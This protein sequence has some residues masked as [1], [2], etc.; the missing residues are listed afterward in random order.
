MR[1]DEVVL[2]VTHPADPLHLDVLGRGG[3]VVFSKNHKVGPRPAE[4]DMSE[5]DKHLR[6]I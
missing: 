1:C 5:A 3:A 4:T 2:L 6:N